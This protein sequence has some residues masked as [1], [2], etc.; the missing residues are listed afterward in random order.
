MTTTAL[1]NLSIGTR[2]TH[3][4]HETPHRVVDQRADGTQTHVCDATG[5]IPFPHWLV[6]PATVQ[7]CPIPERG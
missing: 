7:V 5:R 3:P 2:F 6:M 1:G 4:G